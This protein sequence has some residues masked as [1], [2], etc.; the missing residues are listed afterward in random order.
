MNSVAENPRAVIGGNEP[1]EPSP[2]EV[3]TKAVE[4]AFGEAA[5]WLDGAKVDSQALA[6]GIGNLLKVIRDA[7]KLADE[8]RK[9]ENEPFDTGKAEV[10]ARYKPLLE[11]ADLAASACKKALAPWLEAE[12]A[13]L[14]REAALK[15]E[16][17]QEATRKAQEAIRAADVANLAERAAAEALIKDA[18][19]A[20]TIA[21]RAEKQ[22]ASAGGSFGKVVSLR[23]T[24]LP[25][26]INETDFARFVW[27]EHR[28]ELV[29]FLVNLARRLVDS[30]QRGIPGV[31]VVERKQA[32]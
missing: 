4:D 29:E 2:F 28:D 8:N 9:V 12:D 18:K 7:R 3:A 16:A 19:K 22:T 10:Q 5:L 25:H 27:K 30:G 26:I 23:T 6:D 21:H 17:A 20:E 24:Y 14:A 31:E 11:K 32:V 13:R 1:P 15:R